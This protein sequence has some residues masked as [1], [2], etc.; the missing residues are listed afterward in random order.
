MSK[1]PTVFKAELAKKTKE[2]LIDE[3]VM[4]YKKLPEVKK[5]YEMIETPVLEV[6]GQ[7]KE[8]IR[9]EFYGTEKNSLPKVRL[10]VARKA[11]NDFKKISKDSK[12]I[13]DLNLYYAECLAGFINDY[14]P[15]DER[16]YDSAE[17]LY[18]QVLK[19]AK[20]HDLLDEFQPRLYELHE[21]A[22]DGWGFKDQLEEIYFDYF[23]ELEEC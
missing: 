8:T 7:Y 19:Q 23:D 5:Y 16:F 4:L 21:K 15:D 6:L 2:A 9:R 3:L 18:A 1:T 20:K 22:S 12:L 17:N 11:L 14:G 10:S 13:L